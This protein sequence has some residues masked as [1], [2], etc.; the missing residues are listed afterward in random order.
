MAKWDL[1]QEL[2]FG[3]TSQSPLILISKI[4]YI[5]DSGQKHNYLKQIRKTW[6]NL[7]LVIKKKKKR[8]NKLE[9]EGNLPNTLK[10]IYKRLQLTSYIF[11]N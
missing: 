1:L 10:S 11:L 6:Q 2:T 3:L 4:Y 9:I 7:T 5:N 8:L